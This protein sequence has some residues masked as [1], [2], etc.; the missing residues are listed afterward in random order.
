MKTIYDLTI[1]LL[2]PLHIG[3]GDTLFGNFDFA[4]HNRQTWVIDPEGFAG[5]LLDTDDQRFNQILSGTPLP[6][7]LTPQDY[8]PASPM[9]RYVLPGVPHRGD[10]GVEIR[11]HIKNV[12]DQPYIPGSSLKGALRTC[13]FREA[14]R[15]KNQPLDVTR[16]NRSRNW[17]AQ[18]LEN[19]LLSSTAPNRGQSPNYSLLRAL[20]VADSDPVEAQALVL[21]QAKVFGVGNVKASINVECLRPDTVLKTTLTID[22]YLF[23]DSQASQKLRLGEQ[24]NWIKNLRSLINQQ[25]ETRVKQE[26]NFYE[27]RGNNLAG[28]FYKT[29]LTAMPDMPDNRFLLQVGWGGGWDNKTLSFLLPEE[30]KA[31]VVE[32]YN[33]ARN[34]FDRGETM[35]PR[36]RRAV[37]RG[38]GEQAQ[39]I[40]PLGW[41]L[42]EM[43]QR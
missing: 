36:T 2:T 8:D 22:E 5:S 7:L 41:M 12:Y 42:V 17:A 30:V 1:T 15:Q 34:G 21:A 20:Q 23:T 38:E 4:I 43:A 32:K 10:T 25:A 18:S 16:L 3:D 9:F 27:K 39:P 24:Q 19:E 33:L 11:S 26:I 6:Q 31:D 40:R 37:S 14:F 13:I 28:D 35:F 29:L